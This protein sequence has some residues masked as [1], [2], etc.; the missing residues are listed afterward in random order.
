MYLDIY[1]YIY[2]YV[3]KYINICR[4][5]LTMAKISVRDNENN[6]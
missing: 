1:T 5:S 2:I 4:G 6:R 3:Y